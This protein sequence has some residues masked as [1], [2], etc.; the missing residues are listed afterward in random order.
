MK[1]R[2]E[3]VRLLPLLETFRRDSFRK[4]LRLRTGPNCQYS[5]MSLRHLIRPVGAVWRQHFSTA[6]LRRV[7]GSGGV[8]RSASTS[9]QQLAKWSGRSVFVLTA[10]AGIIGFGVAA[11]WPK[12][13]PN[14][15]VLLFDSKP[16][17]LAMRPCGK[18]KL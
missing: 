13:S 3:G 9:T 12:L 2:G 16:T 1:T 4:S 14:G 7:A 6:P 17:P 10:T 18:W 11:Y 5:T 15:R 8:G